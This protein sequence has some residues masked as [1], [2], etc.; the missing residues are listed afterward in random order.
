MGIARR[1][2]LLAKMYGTVAR[3]LRR[4]Q[5]PRPSPAHDPRGSPSG[6]VAARGGRGRTSLPAGDMEA[7]ISRA[8]V[9]A[10]ITVL[11]SLESRRRSSST[12]PQGGIPE[13]E[14]PSLRGI[15]A[16]PWRGRTSAVWTWGDGTR[17]RTGGSERLRKGR[18]AQPVRL[19]ARR[20]PTT[21]PA[22][23]WRT[24]WTG[25]TTSARLAR[26]PF[27]PRDRAGI[28]RWST[29]R[30]SSRTSVWALRL[31]FSF[32]MDE[33]TARPGLLRAGF[34]HAV[35]RRPRAQ[36]STFPPIPADDW[37]KWRFGWLLDDQLG[38]DLPRPDPVRA[39][40]KASQAPV[41][42]RPPVAPP[43]PVHP[44]A[45][46]W[47][48]STSRST[49]RRLLNIAAEALQ[50]SACPSRNVAEPSR[51]SADAVHGADEEG[52]ELL[53]LDSG[54]GP[55]HALP[56]VSPAACSSSRS[57]V[58]PDEPCRPRRG[59]PA[60]LRVRSS[61]VAR[62]LGVDGSDRRRTAPAPALPGQGRGRTPREALLEAAKPLIDEE[63]QPPPAPPAA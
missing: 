50:L 6:P 39:E 47:R 26:G 58:T 42:P 3:S 41:H 43:E 30:S 63:T 57:R 18:R 35:P 54:R 19:G 28:L 17:V 24:G 51:G 29:R 25:T 44:R 52:V 22:R 2:F 53:V 31:R 20:L 16:G 45:A 21:T 9:A 32:G 48:T 27:P 11:D 59:V 61:L 60:D 8:A 12:S 56:G 55:R 49:R 1:G 38:A 14:D 37:R 62:F 34:R 5:L 33:A 4:G 36:H 40:Q 10:M 15:A 23:S 46:R 7:R 13:C